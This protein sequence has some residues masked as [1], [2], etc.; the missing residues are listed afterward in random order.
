M[1]ALVIKIRTTGRGELRS[2]D[3]K[4]REAAPYFFTIT[5]YLLLR[6]QPLTAFGGAPRVASN[7]APRGRVENTHPFSVTRVIRTRQN[8]Q[9]AGI[10][11]VSPPCHTSCMAAS[12]F[13]A[14]A[15]F[16]RVLI[17][18]LTSSRFCAG[19]GKEDEAIVGLW[20][21]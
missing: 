5:F 10:C 19:S 14:S 2:P 9:K 1:G 6:Q 7:L 15:G 12:S 11:F 17:F 4:C 20:Q 18:D 21:G 16:W 3:I 8:P 13:L